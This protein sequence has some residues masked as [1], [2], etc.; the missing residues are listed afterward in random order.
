MISDMCAGC[1]L[2]SSEYIHLLKDV[3]EEARGKRHLCRGCC[4]KE[5]LAGSLLPGMT[6]T[7]TAPASSLKHM[8][9]CLYMHFQ[10]VEI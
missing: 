9:T 1:T 6:S 5:W 3:K 4:G 8:S 7:G 2:E 10:L